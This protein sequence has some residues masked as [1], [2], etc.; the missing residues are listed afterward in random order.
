M[1]VPLPD[2]HKGLSKQDI[3]ILLTLLIVR[4]A[5]NQGH[6]GQIAVACVVRNRVALSPLYGVGW[7]GVM[8]KPKQFSC[9]NNPPLLG[10][11]LHPV[12]SFISASGW[13]E[14]GWIAEK[15]YNG[16]MPDITGGAT[17]YHTITR[18]TYAKIWPPRW[19]RK[20]IHTRRIGEHEFLAV[21]SIN[22]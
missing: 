22:D 21:G 19:A 1:G 10:N 13:E 2:P 8:L 7:R 12:P 18:P 11:L 14:V 15:V 6:E 5:A 16:S 9:F 4:E 17:H 20:M 3:L